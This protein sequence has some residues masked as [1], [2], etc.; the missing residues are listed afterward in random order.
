MRTG[1]YTPLEIADTRLNGTV[2]DVSGYLFL[3]INGQPSAPELEDRV[4]GLALE[5]F[6]W[7]PNVVAVASERNKTLPLLGALRSGIIGTLA[8]SVGNVR[9]IIEL[10]EQTRAGGLDNRSGPERRELILSW[11]LQ[12]RTSA[13]ERRHLRAR[14]QFKNPG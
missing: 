7:I 4:I 10:D 12:M 6:R 9:L 14:C 8:T 1:W 11:A 13:C 2:V 3:D 5:D